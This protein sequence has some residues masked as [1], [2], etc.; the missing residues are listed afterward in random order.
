MY[1]IMECTLSI[2]VCGFGSM[3]SF[4]TSKYCNGT[5]KSLWL[6]PATFLPINHSPLSPSTV[7][8]LRNSERKSTIF[9][10]TAGTLTRNGRCSMSTRNTVIVLSRISWCLMV[11]CGLQLNTGPSRK[12]DKQAGRA[13]RV[14][15]GREVWEIFY[16]FLG[17]TTHSFP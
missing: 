9:W 8:S 15:W 3:T 17:A 10:T 11:I 2:L 7:Y 5:T 14:G 13:R 12:F 16:H 6:H 4:C 1:C